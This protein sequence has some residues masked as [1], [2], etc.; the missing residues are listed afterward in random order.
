MTH[1]I[2]SF[3]LSQNI[4]RFSI[5]N[6]ICLHSN[7]LLKQTSSK[8]SDREALFILPE[9]SCHSSSSQTFF[10]HKVDLAKMKYFMYP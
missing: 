4:L 5:P 7:H 6:P 3:W 9:A 8:V 2:P 10:F 1:K